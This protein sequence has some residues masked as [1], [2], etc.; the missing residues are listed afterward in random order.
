MGYEIGTKRGVANHYGPRGTDGQYGGQDNS[1]GKIKEASWTFDYDKLPAYTASNLEQ[2]LPANTTVVSAHLRVITAAT[3]AGTPALNIGLTTTAGVVVDL[4]GLA[5]PAQMTWA[6]L[7][8]KGSRIAGAGALIGT[9]IG[10]SACEV[11]VAISDS[12]T[13]TAGKF[14]L[15]VKYQYN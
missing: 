3:S 8:V 12:D 9:T 10:T 7:A 15:V 4:D 6:L 13:F 14:E 1:V 5:A 2:S 11:T